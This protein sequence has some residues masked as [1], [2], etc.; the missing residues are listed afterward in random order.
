MRKKPTCEKL[1]ETIGK[2]ESICISQDIVYGLGFEYQQLEN[3]INKT[4]K[5]IKE[6]K[7]YNFSY[8]KEEIFYTVSDKKARNKLLSILDG[9]Q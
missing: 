3:K 8:D 1:I 4:I 2:K 9:D 6:N 5:Y 7:L